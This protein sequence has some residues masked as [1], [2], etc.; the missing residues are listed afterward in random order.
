M[1]RKRKYEEFFAYEANGIARCRR[2][3]CSHPT[4]PRAQSNGMK[5]HVRV[6]HPDDYSRFLAL[7]QQGRADGIP[8]EGGTSAQASEHPL[9][10]FSDDEGRNVTKT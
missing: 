6:H 2:G 3:G 7:E 5:N 4:M 1:P 9:E 8:S 10:L